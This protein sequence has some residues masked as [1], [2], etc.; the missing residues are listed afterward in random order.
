MV[1]ALHKIRLQSPKTARG[2]GAEKLKGLTV[3]KAVSV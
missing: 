1:K 3:K 2:R